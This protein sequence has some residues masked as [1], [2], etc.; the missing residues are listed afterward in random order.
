MT[1]WFYVRGSTNRVFHRLGGSLSTCIRLG[2]RLLGLGACREA[3]G[4]VTILSC[5][6]VLLF[7]TFFTVLFVFLTLNFFLKSLFNSMNSK[8]NIMTILCLLLVNVVIVGGSEVDGGMLG[9]IVSTL[10]AGSS[11]AG[12]ASGRR[13]TASAS[14]RASF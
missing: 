4:I 8:F 11:G 5:N 13:S 2:L 6:I 9:I 1:R 12:T 7:L 14:K 3:K 10:A